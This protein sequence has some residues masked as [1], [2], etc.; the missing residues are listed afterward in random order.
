MKMKIDFPND[1]SHISNLAF[2]RALLIRDTI[3]N[4][5]DTYEEKEQVRREILN[6]LK[7]NTE[8]ES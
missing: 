7:E 5:C 3:N 1:N 4:I 6:Y 8:L 2:I